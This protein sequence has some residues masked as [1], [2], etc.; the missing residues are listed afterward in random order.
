MSSF[1]TENSICPPLQLGYFRW[2]SQDFPT[3]EAH[4]PYFKEKCKIKFLY[5]LLK[6]Q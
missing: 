6:T 5:N 4:F 1:G 2:I 3:S